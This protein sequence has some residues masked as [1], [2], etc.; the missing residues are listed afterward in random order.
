MRPNDGKDVLD[1]QSVSSGN[2]GGFLDVGS[3]SPGAGGDS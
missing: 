1:C 3:L 2:P